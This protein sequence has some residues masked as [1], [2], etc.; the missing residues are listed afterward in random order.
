MAITTI[1]RKRPAQS[2]EKQV[3]QLTA[4]I[5][6]GLGE[7]PHTGAYGEIYMAVKVLGG[8]AVVQL[9]QEALAIQNAGGMKTK[10]GKGRRTL[11]GV[12]FRLL[13]NRLT[14]AQKRRIYPQSANMRQVRRNINT[15]KF[16]RK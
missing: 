5:A 10:D 4:I 16:V 1:N 14:P 2:E 7:K 12:F 13:K 15:S 11:G 3:G 8:R 9:A 6:D